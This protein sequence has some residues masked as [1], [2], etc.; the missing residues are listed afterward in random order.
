MRTLVG[1]RGSILLGLHA[2]CGMAP[3]LAAE[4]VRPKVGL[5]AT[6]RDWCL[7]DHPRVAPLQ[8]LSWNGPVLVDV[9]DIF[10]RCRR[11]LKLPAGRAMDGALPRPPSTW[12]E[13]TCEPAA[14]MSLDAALCIAQAAGL[15][16]GIEPPV[17]HL[18]IDG[19][20]GT[21]T[22]MIQVVQSRRSDGWSA[23]I[24]QVDAIDGTLREV[25]G[26]R[27]IS[28]RDWPTRAAAGS[29]SGAAGSWVRAGLD[30][31]ASVAAFARHVLELL[32]LGAPMALVD[33]AGAALRDE[34]RHTEASFAVA[35][36]L[37]GRS[38]APGPLDTS[39]PPRST[40]EAILV[41]L[42][43]EGCLGETLATAEARV[44]ATRTDDPDI[45]R[46]LDD[47]ARDETGHATL[48]WKT[49]AWGLGAHPEAREAVLAALAE[50]PRA[51]TADAWGLLGPAERDALARRVLRTVVEP[52]VRA[53]ASGG[54]TAR[55]HGASRVGPL[56][57]A[58]TPPDHPMDCVP[59]LDLQA[60]RLLG[61]D[62]LR[63][64]I[65]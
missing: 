35:S 2:G 30:E 23:D 34:V 4:P 43:R 45:R 27:V 57:D 56:D 16:K 19:D 14:W 42:A 26:A 22:W 31:H 64:R 17:A 62:E 24:F 8:D 61:A 12:A 58:L 9:V 20:L 18:W 44:A 63:Y 5:D 11:M 59:P 41:A 6:F 37:A 54:P 28:G 21:V 46:V 52:A 3:A 40:P 49:L 32:S 15:P 1:L 29:V 50:L 47:I 25:T 13:D 39:A 51:A 53:L 33:A 38:L 48:A 10:A 7:A 65:D 55:S 36:R 60:S